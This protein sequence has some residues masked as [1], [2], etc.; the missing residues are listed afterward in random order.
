MPINPPTPPSPPFPPPLWALTI[1][2]AH[3][4]V[5]PNGVSHGSRMKSDRYFVWQEED[6]NDLSADNLHSERA[7]CGYTDLFTKREFD[8]W[9]VQLENSFDSY[10]ISWNRTGMT[11]EPDTGFFH[12]SWDWE[13]AW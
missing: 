2:N 8:P 12:W 7:M 6:D 5:A 4:D 9:I 3:L 11:Y 10:G 13:V 1:I